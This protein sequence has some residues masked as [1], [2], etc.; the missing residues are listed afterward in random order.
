MLVT[1]EEGTIKCLESPFNLFHDYTRLEAE[2]LQSKPNLFP[3]SF[4]EQQMIRILKHNPDP[5]R[6]LSDTPPRSVI[7]I[8]R[9]P[10]HSR[11]QQTI[12]LLRQCRLTRTVLAHDR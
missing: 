6:Q 3:D 1:T 2:V 4:R 8:D 10:S 9:H 11:F 7:S 12:Q 5:S